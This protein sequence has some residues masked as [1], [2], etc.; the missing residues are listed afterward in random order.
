MMIIRLYPDPVYQLF[1]Q[2]NAKGHRNAA[3]AQSDARGAD[4]GVEV[5]AFRTTE[6]LNERPNALIFQFLDRY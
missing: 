6:R 5:C 1:S 2:V 3:A 4:G